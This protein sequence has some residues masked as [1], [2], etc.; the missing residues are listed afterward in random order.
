MT[1]VPY[2]PPTPV[3]TPA[4]GATNQPTRYRLLLANNPEDP[5]EALHCYGGCREASTEDAYIDCLS[6]CPGFEVTVGAKCGPEDGTPRSVCLNSIP[7]EPKRE[8]NP[9]VV[10]A[11]VLLDFV[12]LFSL[13][14]LCS[15][16]NSQC[17]YGY[18]YWRGY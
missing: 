10:V 3:A 2:V 12:L 8:P 13:V 1:S 14:S 16:P 6:Q 4:Y 9:G 17:I 7:P 15:A 18:P 11:A 5:A